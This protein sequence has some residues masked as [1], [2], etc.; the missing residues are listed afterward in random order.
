MITKAAGSPR[1]LY[2]RMRESS[3]TGFRPLP[4]GQAC[5]VLI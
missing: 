1:S 5:V 3:S 4:D 2:K